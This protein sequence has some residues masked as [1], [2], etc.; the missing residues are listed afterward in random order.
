M[1]SEQAA[2]CLVIILLS[3][4]LLVIS[5]SATPSNKRKSLNTIKEVNRKG[6]YIGLITVFPPEEDAFFTTGAFEINPHHPFV[7]LSGGY[8]P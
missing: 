2:K 3:I 5:V 6:P 7:D 1:A 8:P 4:T